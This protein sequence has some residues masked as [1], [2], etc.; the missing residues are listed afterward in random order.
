MKGIFTAIGIITAIIAL[1]EFLVLER[2][3]PY[4]TVTAITCQPNIKTT[5]ADLTKFAKLLEVND[6][7]AIY[8][9]IDVHGGCNNE[10]F[11]SATFSTP[12]SK[13]QHRVDISNA[14]FSVFNLRASSDSNDDV[15]L[16]VRRKLFESEPLSRFIS[17]HDGIRI[18]GLFVPRGTYLEETYSAE[19]IGVGYSKEFDQ[20]H[21][22]THSIAHSTGYFSKIYNYINTCILGNSPS[23]RIPMEK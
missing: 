16:Q 20:I 2:V 1:Y 11:A 10:N 23:L 22:C 8:L 19:L 6:A 18:V 12:D 5:H 3:V 15:Y 13:L 21:K 9:T 14:E 7:K 4:Q 17:T